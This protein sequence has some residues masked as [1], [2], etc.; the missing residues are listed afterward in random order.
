MI[1]PPPPF[2]RCNLSA[3]HKQAHSELALERCVYCGRMLTYPRPPA[4]PEPGF[5]RRPRRAEMG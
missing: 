4:P 5:Y 3:A 1:N 2:C